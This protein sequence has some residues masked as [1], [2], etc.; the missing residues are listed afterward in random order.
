MLVDINT[1]TEIPGGSPYPATY[2]V[3]NSGVSH[4][5]DEQAATNPYKAIV[6]AFPGRNVA[7][8]IIYKTLGEKLI[9]S[10]AGNEMYRSDSSDYSR[11]KPTN[12]VTNNMLILYQKLRSYG[13]KAPYFTSEI[14]ASSLSLVIA[15]HVSNYGILYYT[16]NKGMDGLGNI[17]GVDVQNISALID[18]FFLQDSSSG[19]VPACE[20][21]KEYNKT[22]DDSAI[23]RFNEKV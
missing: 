13:L 3:K 14:G 2:M 6:D 11:L 22:L 10:P 9:G 7:D 1:S 15:K 20:L 21:I 17:G 23:D 19:I 4:K 8:D 5:A 12:I 18:G 16:A